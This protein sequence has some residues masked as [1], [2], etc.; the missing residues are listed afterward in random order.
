M[1]ISEVQKLLS[2]N[3]FC[4][5]GTTKP[6]GETNLMALSW[7]TY[8]STHPATIAVC[9]S[10]RG[11]SGQL[12]EER[13]EF[14][15]SVVSDQIREVAFACGTCSG[16]AVDKAKEFGIALSEPTSIGTRYVE[17]SRA[18]FE[19]KLCSTVPVA[20]HRI[21]IAEIVAIHANPEATQLFAL[22]GYSKLGTLA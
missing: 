18:A 14:T 3:P 22:N 21:F 15:L 2:P 9:L 6:D 11:Y 20:D 19:C 8:V 17:A 4:L 13:G 16:R 1:T 5:I 12:I 10:Q 7:W